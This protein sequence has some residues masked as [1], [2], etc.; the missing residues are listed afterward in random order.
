MALTGALCRLM[1]HSGHYAAEE[2]ARRHRYRRLGPSVA[3]HSRQIVIAIH[4][5][6]TNTIGKIEV[7]HG[8]AR[9]AQ[10]RT[11]PEGF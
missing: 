4:Y 5:A 3:V 2:G 6:K 8:F 9:P 10:S 11:F 7:S 1:T